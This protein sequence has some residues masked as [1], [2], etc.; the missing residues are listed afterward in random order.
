MAQQVDFS[1]PRP[2]LIIRQM[3]A[4]RHVINDMTLSFPCKIEISTN[5]INRGMTSAGAVHTGWD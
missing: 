1:I 3:I 5:G 4:T 2:F